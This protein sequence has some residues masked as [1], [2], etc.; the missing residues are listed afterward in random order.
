MHTQNDGCSLM[1]NIDLCVIEYSLG[2]ASTALKHGDEACLHIWYL[3]SKLSIT[4]PKLSCELLTDKMNLL[5]KCS[6]A[7]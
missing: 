6:S 2:D 5:T 4:S 1:L 3:T 7:I